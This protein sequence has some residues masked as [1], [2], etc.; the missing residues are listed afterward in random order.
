MVTQIITKKFFVPKNAII[1]TTKVNT[2]K[3]N[4]FHRLNFFPS[5][6]FFLFKITKLWYS[7]LF[8]NNKKK[9]LSYR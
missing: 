3:D 9:A 1:N 5:S 6:F 2:A 7:F 8:R 4:Y